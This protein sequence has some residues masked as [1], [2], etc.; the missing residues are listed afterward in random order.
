MA[1]VIMGSQGEYSDRSEWAEAVCETMELAH[2]E[3]LRLDEAERI[4]RLTRGKL[5]HYLYD[6]RTYS[7]CENVRSVVQRLDVR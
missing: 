5:G 1:I 7:I 2:A 4:E 3:I 6:P